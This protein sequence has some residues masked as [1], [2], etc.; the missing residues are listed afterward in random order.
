MADWNTFSKLLDNNNPEAA[1]FLS[2]YNLRNDPKYVNNAAVQNLLAPVEHR[3]FTRGLISDSDTKLGALGNAALMS[4]ATPAYSAAKA[5]SKGFGAIDPRLEFM[6]S[7]S[8]PS[9]DEIAQ[10]FAGI[11]E[12][13]KL[14]FSK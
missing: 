7:R 6:Q 2:L 5:T 14:A 10:G 8:N 1:S 13:L 9:F 3:A 11:G 4:L 12:G